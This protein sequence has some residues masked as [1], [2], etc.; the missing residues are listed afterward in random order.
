M[1]TPEI[2]S[3]IQVD[4]AELMRDNPAALIV[5]RKS[6]GLMEGYFSPV[7]MDPPQVLRVAT[8]SVD[9]GEIVRLFVKDGMTRTK[10]ADDHRDKIL[11]EYPDF[12]FTPINVRD[13]TESELRNPLVVPASERRGG[14]SALTMLQYLRSV[15]PPTVEHSEIAPDRIAAHF[16]NGWVNMVGPELSDKFP[17]LAA[18]SMLENPNAPMATD[19]MLRRFLHEQDQIVPGET[20]EERAVLQSGLLEMASIIRQTKLLRRRIAE[21]AFIL[22]S[23]G[24]EVIGGERQSVRQIYG[25]LNTL[26]ASEKLKKAFPQGVEREMAKT[27]FGNAVVQALFQL[28]PEVD[29]SQIL[30]LLGQSFR[31]PNLNFEQILEIFNS[32]IPLEKHRQI[33]LDINAERLRDRYIASSERSHLTPTEERLIENFGKVAYLPDE[34][35]RRVV[36]IVK[37]AEAVL[38]TATAFGE[39]IKSQEGFLLGCGV[40]PL[41]VQ[42]ILGEVE[43]AHSDLLSATSPTL[44]RKKLQDLRDVLEE[45]QRK[46]S[47]QLNMHK[48]GEMANE[49]YGDELQSGQGA[50]VKR[51]IVLCILRE[52]GNSEPARVK[53]A[54]EQLK[55]LPLDL[56]Y[57]VIRGEM[58]LRIAEQ[59]SR[60]R[61][62]R[63]EDAPTSVSRRDNV[64][65]P[66]LSVAPVVDASLISAPFEEETTDTQV[67]E[68]LRIE[69]NNQ[70]LQEGIKRFNEVLDILD[71][72]LEDMSPENKTASYKLVRR[73]GQY[74]FNHP[75]IVRVVEQHPQL[76]QEMIGLRSMMLQKEQ[77]DITAETRTKI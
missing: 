20:Q 64:V 40:S 26:E 69:A 19:A 28:P 53:L 34:E 47:F 67:L 60:L 75:D 48:I 29:R 45:K 12:R 59:K 72:D 2:G 18:I 39:S 6:Y 38:Y 68:D 37:N 71:L 13:V 43:A 52:V 7:Q 27:A 76:L 62:T 63:E 70:K 4:P 57:Q 21:S 31:D 74:L 8:F 10:F 35:L 17:A 61:S 33:R 66:E 49:V 55:S 32:A 15:V 44:A 16:I 77:A 14:Q 5:N 41:L 65:L 1:R 25:L 9:E 30:S 23:A 22:V 54:L 46:I 36:L 3:L 50:L 58:R 73:L 42:E 24:S 11:P 51:N 56:Q